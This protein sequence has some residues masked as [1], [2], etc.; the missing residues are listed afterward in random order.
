MVGL[1][2][3]TKFIKRGFGRATDNASQDVRAGLLTRE[4]G[5]ELAKKFDTQAPKILDKYLKD[6]EMTEK[7]FY[8]ILKKQREG[9]AKDIP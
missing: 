6:T 2:D 3:Y 4:E 8:E 9:K 1:H 7:E 5:F